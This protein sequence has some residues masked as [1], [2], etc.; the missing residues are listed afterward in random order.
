MKNNHL[1]NEALIRSFQWDIEDTRK[2]NTRRRVKREARRLE[3]R[4]EKRRIEILREEA[5]ND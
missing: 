1:R 4:I 5:N 3:R 2:R